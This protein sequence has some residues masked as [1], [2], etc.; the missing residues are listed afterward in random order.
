MV[1]LKAKR[2]K[3]SAPPCSSFLHG[4]AN[5]NS[6][7]TRIMASPLIPYDGAGINRAVDW[8]KEQVGRLRPRRIIGK[9]GKELVW[10][11]KCACGATTHVQA[12]NLRS[13]NTVSCGCFHQDVRRLRRQTEV[14][15]ISREY[16]TW[17]SIKTRCY[18]TKIRSYKDYGGR[19][20]TVCDRW[21]NSFKCFFQDMGRRPAGMTIDRKNNELGYF[22]ENCRWATP[23][24]QANNRR[25]PNV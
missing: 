4:G 16:S 25:K 5:Q 15:C 11:C 7:S 19:G 6:K 9:R 14:G 18:N 22:K 20:I 24:Q 8:S 10:E 17:K 23:K 21:R 1:D 2:R 3:M 13:K 12:N